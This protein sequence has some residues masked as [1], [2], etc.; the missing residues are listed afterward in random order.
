M[1]KNKIYLR[2]LFDLA[3]VLTIF[4]AVLLELSVMYFYLKYDYIVKNGVNLFDSF[5]YPL[6]LNLQLLVLASFFIFKVYRYISCDLSKAISIVYFIDQLLSC[7]FILFG[8]EKKYY[9]G[10]VYPLYGLIFIIALIF[11][12]ARNKKIILKKSSQE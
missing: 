1:N 12:K 5:Y 3:M 11:F 9:I 10:F 7:L 4:V 8:F 6:I 2:D